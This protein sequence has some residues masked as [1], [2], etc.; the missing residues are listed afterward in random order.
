MET[1]AIEEMAMGNEKKLSKTREPRVRRFAITVIVALIVAL[2]AF[3]FTRELSHYV[4]P[5]G[6]YE[7]ESTLVGIRSSPMMY[8]VLAYLCAVIALMV[9]YRMGSFVKSLSPPRRLLSAVGA[10]FGPPIVLGGIPFVIAIGMALA[11]QQS[12]GTIRFAVWTM[13]WLVPW[14]AYMYMVRLLMWLASR[15]WVKLAPYLLGI[16]LMAAMVYPL[17]LWLGNNDGEGQGILALTAAMALSILI[18]TGLADLLVPISSSLT[19]V[20]PKSSSA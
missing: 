4:Y 1:S 2:P 9:S 14:F 12:S 20:G 6:N 18:S 11:S 15:R 19:R 8:V 7:P 5:P 10:I 3:M 13:I 16:A 17:A